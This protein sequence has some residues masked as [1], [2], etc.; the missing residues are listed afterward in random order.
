[1]MFYYSVVLKI[2]YS[3]VLD[4]VTRIHDVY[5]AQEALSLKLSYLLLVQEE[6]HE[7]QTQAPLTVYRVKKGY[8]YRFRLVSS[9][10]QFCPFQ[11][12]VSRII[13]VNWG[14]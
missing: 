3:I 11:L 10:S 7:L 12:Q 1:M 4:Y 13:V 6:E 2:S 8:R 5:G 14:R 9:G